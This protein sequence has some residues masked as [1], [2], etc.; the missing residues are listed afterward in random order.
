MKLRSLAVAGAIAVTGLAAGSAAPAP[1]ATTAADFTCVTVYDFP[2]LGLKY[3][4]S[5]TGPCVVTEYRTTFTGT[6]TRC[7]VARPV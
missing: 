5:T 4:Y 2:D 6:Y 1:A 3:C 7:V